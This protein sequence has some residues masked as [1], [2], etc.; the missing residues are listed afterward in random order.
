LNR[1]ENFV[2]KRVVAGVL[3]GALILL[4][5]GVLVRMLLV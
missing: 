4:A 2:S 5:G 1:R 3:V